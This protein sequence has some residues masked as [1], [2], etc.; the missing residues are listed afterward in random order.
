MKEYNEAGIS[1]PVD[2]HMKITANGI[3][4]LDANRWYKK[5]WRGIGKLFEI[6]VKIFK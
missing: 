3:D 6:V 1:G 4:C 5:V 2:I